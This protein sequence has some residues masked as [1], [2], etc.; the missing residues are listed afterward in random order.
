MLSTYPSIKGRGRGGGGGY[1]FKARIDRSIIAKDLLSSGWK[2]NWRI[3]KKGGTNGTNLFHIGNF[4]I[5]T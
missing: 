2:K 1:S 5:S 3:E 4:I